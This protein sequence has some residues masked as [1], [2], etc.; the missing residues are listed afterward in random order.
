MSFPGLSAEATPDSWVELNVKMRTQT[1]LPLFITGILDVTIFL[2][3]FLPFLTLLIF[4]FSLRI[5]CRTGKR[6][7]KQQRREGAG[8]SAFTTVSSCKSHERIMQV[9]AHFR[10]KESEIGKIRQ[11]KVTQHSKDEAIIQTQV[12][13]FYIW[14]NQVIYPFS[15]WRAS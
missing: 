3:F 11:P 1:A 8:G 2:R 4:L 9:L 10:E 14:N 12:G 5:T 6:R 13:L 7:K 15:Y